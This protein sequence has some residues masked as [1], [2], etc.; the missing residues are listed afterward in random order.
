MILLRALLFFS[1]TLLIFS[2]C[3]VKLEQ[4]KELS[5]AKFQKVLW[6]DIPGFQTDN[7]AEAFKVFQ[8]D[9]Q[10]PMRSDHLTEVCHQSNTPQAI[11]NPRAFFIDSFTPY[12]VFTKEN[13]SKGVITGYYEPLLYG[14]FTQTQRYK[15]PIYALPSDLVRVRLTSIY[16]DLKNFTLRGKVEKNK[17]IPYETREEIEALGLQ[18]NS[19]L[20]PLCYVDDK[21]DLFFL[22]IQ[23]SG[24]VQLPNN[25]SINIGFAGQNG[26]PYYAIG[27]KL[28]EMNVLPLEE[29]SLQSIKKW[30][31]KNPSKIDEILNLNKSYVFFKKSDQQATG[32]L[33]T[34]LVANRNVAVDRHSIPLGFP[35]FINTTNPLTYAPLQKL[36]IAADTGGAI[37]GENRAD[38]FF[39]NGSKAEELAGKMNQEGELFL[40][41]PKKLNSNATINTKD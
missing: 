38:L 1:L 2:G 29:I 16:P 26:H 3:S 21:I 41:I 17:L 25:R 6:K 7:I 20:E 28:L 15:Y 40:F 10:S 5:N 34:E 11:E 31:E 35:V 23:G 27:R 33:G 39:G 30:L 37:K 19:K 12:K 36:M 22:Q 32:S 18:Q 9:C 13:T 14:S 24:K 4:K 8:K